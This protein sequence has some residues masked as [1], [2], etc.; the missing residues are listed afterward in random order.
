[1]SRKAAIAAAAAL[2][3]VA[4][5]ASIL[6]VALAGNRR[7]EGFADT[8]AP[9][10]ILHVSTRGAPVRIFVPAS[11]WPLP[12]RIAERLRPIEGRRSALAVSW[13]GADAAD[14]DIFVG[15]AL[16]ALLLPAEG[17]K[18][19]DDAKQA[20]ARMP[21]IAAAIVDVDAH[22]HLVLEVDAKDGEGDDGTRRATLWD[23]VK[24]EARW[25]RIAFEY[26]DGTGRAKAAALARRAWTAATA[27]RGG[28]SYESAARSGRVALAVAG[29]SADEKEALRVRIAWRVLPRS[30]GARAVFAPASAS[31]GRRVLPYVEALAPDT[32]EAVVASAPEMV[33]KTIALPDGGDAI[34]VLTSRAYFLVAPT[35]STR[36]RPGVEA[37]ADTISTYLVSTVDEAAEMSLMR[38]LGARLTPAAEERVRQVSDARVRSVVAR[39]PYG[40]PSVPVLRE[41][42]SNGEGDA[43]ELVPPGGALP[44]TDVRTV[45]YRLRDPSGGIANPAHGGGVREIVLSTDVVSGVRV[46]V[47]DRVVLT[48]GTYAVTEVGTNVV[49]QNPLVI[50]AAEAKATRRLGRDIFAAGAGAT[51]WTWTVEVPLGSGRHRAARVG[52]DVVVAGLV[53]EGGGGRTHPMLGRVTRVT[54]RSVTIEVDPERMAAARVAAEDQGALRDTRDLLHPLSRCSADPT[55]PTRQLCRGATDA[56][57][58]E[59]EGGSLTPARWDRPCEHDLD[60]PYYSPASGRGGCLGGGMCEVPIGV[61]RVGSRYVD[62]L[63]ARPALCWDDKGGAD[64]GGGACVSP[65]FHRPINT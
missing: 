34:E 58:P 23:A 7:R 59:A 50:D 33:L 4:V 8:D 17:G 43:V 27:A 22:W 35:T 39:S 25:P 21:R 64:G 42:F 47:G 5:T 32:A 37:V 45:R 11:A 16:D 13:V 62:P 20:A 1:M 61:R 49:L 60:C 46:R 31:A 54:N 41:Q 10:R 55:V 65:V 51:A 14:R 28:P 30:S 9:L 56:T 19:Q 12:A 44:P 15:D 24:D 63:R 53:V 40:I 26:D 57:V 6:I 52:D 36:D 3:A 29:G 18:K 2:L 48:H 38:R